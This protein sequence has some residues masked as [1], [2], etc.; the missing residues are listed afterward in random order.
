[1][2]RRRQVFYW[3]SSVFVAFFNEESTRSE[4]VA[5]IL[6]E[7]ESGDVFIITSSFTL[8][9]VIKLKGSNPILISDQKKITD[10][11]EKIIFDLLMRIEK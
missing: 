2:K 11:F 3:D 6:E 8:V 9:E 10:F 7:A 1:M 4:N 5:Q